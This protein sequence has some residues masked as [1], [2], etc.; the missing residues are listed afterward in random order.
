MSTMLGLIVFGGF[1]IGIWF[2]YRLFMRGFTAEEKVAS[3]LPDDFKPDFSYRKGD[4]Y[5]GYE[6]A[7]NRLVLID[8]PHAKVL[9]PRE[10]RSI[11]PV[12]ESM[13]GLKHHW[14]AFDVPD[15]KFPQYKIWFQFR[16][17]LRDSWRARLADIC[18]A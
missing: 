17:G 6:K 9:A 14:I 10:V 18:K 5:V 7:T 3:L 4:T 11:E 2:S 12:E 8:W 16:R 15:S 13:L 1:T